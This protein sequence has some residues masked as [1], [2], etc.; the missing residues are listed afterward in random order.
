MIYFCCD[1]R[2]RS[3]VRLLNGIDVLLL[4]E[5]SSTDARKILEAMGWVGHD[6]LL[7]RCFAAVPPEFGRGNVRVTTLD[8]RPLTIVDVKTLA[9]LPPEAVG[10]ILARERHFVVVVP[11]GRLSLQLKHQFTL[12]A[13]ES[14]P[15]AE[16]R[17]SLKS[18]SF[19][20]TPRGVWQPTTDEQARAIVR[21]LNGIDYV[22]VVDAEAEQPSERQRI[23]KLYFVKPLAPGRLVK[24]N[25]RIEGGERIRDIKVEKIIPDDTTAPRAGQPPNMLE[26]RVD[27]A[28]DFSTYTLRL[29]DASGH[30]VTNFDPLLSAVAFSFK[31]EC[32]DDFD[33][34]ARVACSPEGVA[35]PEIDY[36][37]KDYNSFRRLML[38]RFSVLMPEWAERNA[39]DLGVVLVEMLAYV[40]DH[41]SYQQDAIATEAYLGTARRRSSVRRHARLVDYFMH[42]GS[43]A[44]VWA[45]CNVTDDR[46][47][48]PKGT[49]LFTRVG[50]LEPRVARDS[51]AYAEALTARPEF[52]ETLNA[53]TFY[54]SH[55]EISFYTWGERECCIAEG[56]TR[57]TLRDGSAATGRLRLRAGDVLVFAERLGP[58]T[59][60]AADADLAHRHAVRL[61]RVAP[62]ARL[63]SDG[64]DRQ[65]SLMPV[66]DQLTGQAVVEI[67]WAD[68][69]ALPFPLC[70]SAVAETTRR[71]FPE[72]S[73]ALGNVVLADHG[74]TVRDEELEVV[75]DAD[76]RLA[77][78]HGQGDCCESAE[79]EARAPRFRPRLKEAPLTFTAELT[80]SRTRGRKRT[81]ASASSVYEWN[82]R[83]VLPAVTLEPFGG[84]SVWRPRRDLLASDEFAPEFV[85]EVEDDGAATLRFGDDEYGMRPAAGTRFLATYRV[86]NGA[87]GNIGA[88][89][90]AHVVTDDTRITSVTN[91]LPARGGQDAES[92]E[93]VRQSAPSAFRTQER[94]ITPEDYAEVAGRHSQVQ[95][96]AAT[97]RWT[98]SWLTIFLTVDRLGGRAVDD[99]FKEEL[100]Q[101]LERYRLAGH[102]VEING[103]SFVPLEIELFVCI[104]PGY[105]RS[106]VR[107]ALLEILSNRTLVD[108][109]QG[110]FHPDKF[111]FGQ[112]VYLSTI[113]AAAQGV[114]GVRY[115]E[116]KKFKRFGGVGAFAGLEGGELSVGRLEIARLDNNPNFPERGV[117]RL[118][119]E[120]GR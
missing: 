26:V 92:I 57:A 120:G 96:A 54:E 10:S 95:R 44:R 23:L 101:H 40:G 7:V 69:D 58:D 82:M 112:S 106:D 77:V 102:D 104:L 38:D 65:P 85:A 55:N 109:R 31:V 6:L 25:I 81:A 111:T 93:H 89:S 114:E 2:R 98:G 5:P 67:E 14:A 70:L 18:L 51:N 42:D 21:D 4:C 48:L 29:V 27:R 28:G 90:L 83:G 47:V 105:F 37:A 34:R 52:F 116:V 30:A 99:E 79:A 1:E 36:L 103:P 86:G 113:L 73:V 71:Y 72:V 8:G 88:E 74:R 46:V 39:A 49:Q 22:E 119:L 91:P 97:V 75:P 3:A 16:F 41:L 17:A 115:V 76:P 11:P 100:R 78:A 35:E 64:Q 108:G 50:R 15:L 110:L 107:A 61:T 84:G 94:A 56:A 32:P 20:A 60:D 66:Y 12:V 59:G 9:D 24:E 45:Q 62:E 63:T 87:R 117:L 68:E 53:A 19:F 33:C 80:R 118:T 13:T 43:N